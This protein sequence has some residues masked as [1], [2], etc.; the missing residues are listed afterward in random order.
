MLQSH[1]QQYG[2]LSDS[3]TFS[4]NPVI[5]AQKMPGLYCL[6]QRQTGKRVVLP[7][8]RWTLNFKHPSRAA[9]GA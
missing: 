4:C 8:V 1:K 9:K 7:F 5:L 2:A 6:N 3:L